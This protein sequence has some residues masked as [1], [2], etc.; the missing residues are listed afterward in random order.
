MPARATATRLGAFIVVCLF[1]GC[2]SGKSDLRP[3]GLW[4]HA[5]RASVPTAD[6][7]IF[8]AGSTV[9]RH[10]CLGEKFQPPR[11]NTSPTSSTYDGLPF[12]CCPQPTT[13]YPIGVCDSNDYIPA[14][15]RTLASSDAYRYYLG[16]VD[17]AV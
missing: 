17:D 4:T 13:S 7:D 14:D 11:S 15:L 9:A 16:V 6:V 2:G 3:T 1:A 8:V 12:S 10:E 5:I